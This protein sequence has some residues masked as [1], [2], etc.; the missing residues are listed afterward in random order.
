MYD[1][2][3]FEVDEE[4]KSAD[5]DCYKQVVHTKLWDTNCPFGEST[6]IITG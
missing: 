4:G 1:V 6:K 3:V 2:F 5:F